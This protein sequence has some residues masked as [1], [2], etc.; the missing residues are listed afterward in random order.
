[1]PATNLLHELLTRSVIGAFYEVYNSLGYG[2]LEHVYVAALT[3]E[4]HSLGHEVGREVS[5]P[6]FYK[7]EQVA[8]QRLDMMVDS[9]L[10]VEIKSTRVLHDGAIRQVA[11][12]LSATNLEVGLLLHFGPRAKFYRLVHTH[13]DRHKLENSPRYN[14]ENSAPQNPENSGRHNPQNP[15]DPRHTS[16]IVAGSSAQVDNDHGT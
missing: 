10:V 5:V 9:K 12:Y 11:S 1:V 4:L 14:P 7:G 16:V 2:F 3:R 15:P 6:I 13:Y 8:R